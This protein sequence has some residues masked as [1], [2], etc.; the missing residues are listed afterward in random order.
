VCEV[1]FIT[2]KKTGMHS[3]MLIGRLQDIH[4]VSSRTCVCV[5]ECVFVC[6]CVC[7][8][9]C[10]RVCM[11]VCACEGVQ[12]FSYVCVCVCVCVCV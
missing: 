6:M 1:A 4:T 12:M 3:M 7:V 9:V 8:S 10:V 2:F 11:S 5:C